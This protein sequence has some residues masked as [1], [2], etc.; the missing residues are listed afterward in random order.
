[1]LSDMWCNYT[2]RRRHAEILGHHGVDL[3][4]CMYNRTETRS[5][6]DTFSRQTGTLLAFVESS[7]HPK[8]FIF[9]ATPFPASPTIR[10]SILLQTFTYHVGPRGH[11]SIRPDS[12]SLPR[13]DPALSKFLCHFRC[14]S[15]SAGSSFQLLT[16]CSH[17][18]YLITIPHPCR[19]LQPLSSSPSAR[20]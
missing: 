1:M 2:V 17:S 20:F 9:F 15:S 13:H 18:G 6:D 12:N 5:C 3:F 4:V 7:M 16:F 10:P 14:P 8:H 11:I 19:F